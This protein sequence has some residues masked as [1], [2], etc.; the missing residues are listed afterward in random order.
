MESENHLKNRSGVNSG[1]VLPVFFGDAVAKISLVTAIVMLAFVCTVSAQQAPAKQASS[2]G[3]HIF[4][5][6]DQVA[7]L[8]LGLGNYLGGAGYKA[9]FLPIL[10][11]YE[12]GIKDGFPIDEKSSLGIG[13]YLAYFGNKFT[14]ANDSQSIRYSYFTIGVRGNLHYQFVDKLDTYGGIMLGAQL[15]G[16]NVDNGARG[17]GFAFSVYVGARY[18]FAE[19]WAAFAEAGYSVAPLEI[20]IAY[21]F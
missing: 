13:G 2:S 7:H 14:W 20:G 11:S 4:A 15:V 17:S 1:R 19:Q 21:K 12:H 6:G 8:G 3:G 18:Y 5:K 16:S 9:S 10:V